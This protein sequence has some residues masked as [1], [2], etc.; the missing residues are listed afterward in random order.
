MNKKD[1]RFNR[2]DFLKLGTLAGIGTMMVGAD[3]LNCSKKFNTS[4]GLPNIAPMEKVR[5]GFVGVGMQ[6]SS[7]VRNFLDIEHV[8]IKAICDIV[9]DK[10]VQM[11]ELVA[12]AGRPVPT[13][14]FRN[15][16]DF[17]RMCE[18]EE[19]D[20]VF[21]STPWNWHVPICVA[22]MKNGKHAATEVPAAVTIDE[23]WELVE[24]A[25]KYGK[26]CVMMENCCYG[27]RE[28]MIF[29]M[30]RRNLLGELIHAECGYLHDLREL[31]LG[32]MYEGRWRIKHSIKYDGNLYPTHGL[33]PIAQCMDINRGDQFDYLV[34]MSSK[35]RGLNLYAIDHFGADH[36]Y[37]RQQYK[38]GDVNVS[39]I[40][41]VK[42]LTITLYHD[43]NLP[44]PYSRISM[45]QGTKGIVQGYP[46]RIHIEGRSPQ[47]QWEALETYKEE[48]EHPLWQN[49]SKKVLTTG[50]GGMDYLEDYR[51]VQALLNGTPTDMDVYD[52]AAW[53]CVT[54]LTERSV[55][56]KSRP[57][58][59]P[60]FTR[61]LWKK[62]EKLEI[63]V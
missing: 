11:Q 2:R 4:P 45:L 47:H 36:E 39:L 48:F 8:E 28:L 16:Y 41:T 38:L 3:I 17:I 6:G 30:V 40:K 24:T 12:N 55:A 5:I 59:F 44:R 20:L 13:G 26:H 63:E 46:D 52:A 29:N 42:N 56:N 54:E 31:K 50:H 23:C 27:W 60:D 33:G 19:L 25:E 34:S 32:D 10:V 57:I 51:L 37:A 21:T 43:T 22:A 35:A 18:Q 15:E 61:G 14:Y 49:L 1:S 7:H 9:E 58:S 53:S 62:R